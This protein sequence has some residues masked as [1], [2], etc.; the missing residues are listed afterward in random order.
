MQAEFS[1][2]QKGPFFSPA[3]PARRADALAWG[4]GPGAP[5]AS[6]GLRHVATVQLVVARTGVDPRAPQP[7]R[8]ASAASRLGFPPTAPRVA[9]GSRGRDP[10][11]LSG[12]LAPG[13]VPRPLAPPLGNSPPLQAMRLA[14][15]SDPRKRRR[16]TPPLPAEASAGLFPSADALQS[17]RD[18]AENLGRA[19]A[20][21][22]PISI[23]LG[24]G[25]CWV[26]PF[27]ATPRLLW[28]IRRQFD[29]A[30]CEFDTHLARC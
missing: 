3:Q 11:V 5:P 7:P 4:R 21:V 19:G 16:L 14:C 8:R 29:A 30:G 23:E 10:A 26:D 20:V 25:R 22:D 2:R 13:K 15:R 12:S 1:A 9:A 18:V 6:A 17:L 28:L 27:R 24:S